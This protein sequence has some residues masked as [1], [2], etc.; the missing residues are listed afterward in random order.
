MAALAKA[1][2]TARQLAWSLLDTRVH[3]EDA[4]G[5]TAEAAT[6]IA[7]AYGLLKDVPSDGLSRQQQTLL[8]RG[9]AAVQSLADSDARLSALLA[10][11]ERWQRRNGSVEPGTLPAYQ[12]I[13]DFDRR[14]FKDGHRAAWNLLARA[15]AII[16]G[17]E[18][19]LTAATKAQ[20]PIYVFTSGKGDLNELVAA[21]LKSRLQRAGFQTVEGRNDA[22]LIIDVAVD[23]MDE[24]TEDFSD[25]VKYRTEAHLTVNAMWVAD[26]SS[27][28]AEAVS[29]EAVVSDRWGAKTEAILRSIA[30]ISERFDRLVK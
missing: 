6:G 25:G 18:L 27:F 8:E 9:R 29:E 26:Q 13:T 20:V 23:H 19:G 7:A 1:R 17:P 16:R 15:E 28:M 24:P 11:A 30:A 5:E 10:A 22:A 4:S 14:R 3:A 12:A 21:K 2:L